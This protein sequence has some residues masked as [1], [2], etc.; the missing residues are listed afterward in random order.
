MPRRGMLHEDNLNRSAYEG[1]GDQPGLSICIN[2][3]ARALPRRVGPVSC[4]PSLGNACKQVY[5]GIVGSYRS[6]LF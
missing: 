6:V 5:C 1:G 2:H 4:V 3:I